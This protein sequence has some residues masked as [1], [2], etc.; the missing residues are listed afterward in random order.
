MRRQFC[1]APSGPGGVSLAPGPETRAFGNARLVG[2]HFLIFMPCTGM[3]RFG[4][5]RCAALK[6]H[7]IRIVDRSTLLLYVL[8][9]VAVFGPLLAF[10]RVV[11]VIASRGRGEACLSWHEFR[12]EITSTRTSPLHLVTVLPAFAF[13]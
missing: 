7:G 2:Q 4:L 3:L 10:C 9:T 1:R 8:I 13:L 6:A 11:H 5:V 12:T